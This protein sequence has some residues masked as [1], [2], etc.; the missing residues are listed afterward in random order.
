MNPKIRTKVIVLGSL[1]L[2]GIPLARFYTLVQHDRQNEALVSAL[3]SGDSEAALVA[4]NSGAD[5]NLRANRFGDFKVAMSIWE[6]LFSF[7]RAP[8][9]VHQPEDAQKQ[10][11]VLMLA[12]ASGSTALVKALLEKGAQV[13]AIRRDGTTVLMLA[14][15]RDDLPVARLLLEHGA[16]IRLQSK[17]GKTPLLHAASQQRGGEVIKLLL[18]KGADVN[19]RDANGMTALAYVAQRDNA[20]AKAE[21][22]TGLLERGADANAVSRDGSTPLLFASIK[23]DLYL[24]QM[25]LSHHANVNAKNA[26]GVTPLMYAVTGG[27]V[28]VVKLLLDRG[29]QANV[30]NGSGDSPMTRSMNIQPGVYADPVAAKKGAERDLQIMRLLLE[31][32]AY[33]TASD[34]HGQAA[35][36]NAVSALK[37]EFIEILLAHGAS[38]HVRT[39]NGLTLI[40]TVKYRIQGASSSEDKQKSDRIIQLLKQAGETV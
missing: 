14:A 37:P 21:L 16:D 35:M 24:T 23:P 40:Q 31:H 8:A 4:V 32:G 5:P 20:P 1:L 39:T 25:L 22:M 18:T 3:R 19:Q 38:P 10:P 33:L 28:P 2:A 12:E 17:D 29:A 26:A 11:T 36:S 15:G 6:R 9:T 13:D 30:S 7:F 27:N 34:P